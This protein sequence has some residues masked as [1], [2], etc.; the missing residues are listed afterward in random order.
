MESLTREG[1]AADTEA[2]EKRRGAGL[3]LRA[4]AQDQPLQ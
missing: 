3:A 1:L 4:P 2:A